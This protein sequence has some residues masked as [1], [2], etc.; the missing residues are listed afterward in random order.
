MRVSLLKTISL[1]MIVKNEEHVLERCL[2]SVQNKVHEIIIVDTGSTDST[3]QIAKKFTNKIFSFNWRDDF[4]AARN[5]SIK[6]ATSDYILILDADEYLNSEADLVSDISDSCDYY[7]VAIKNIVTR[8]Q[9]FTH[10]GLRMFKNNLNFKYENRLHEHINVIGKENEYLSG[11]MKS[12]IYHLG[13]TEQRMLEKDKNNRNKK[14][15]SLEVAEN[16]TAFNLFNMGKTFYLVSD[17]KKAVEYFERSYPLSLDR[18]YLP[19]L[20]TKL[21]QSLFEI[22][23]VDEALS[24]IKGAVVL[25]PNDTEVRFTQGV[26]F[27]ELNYFRDAMNSFFKCLELGD[28]GVVVTEGSGSY[29]SYLKITE[30]YVKKRFYKEAYLE[31]LKA[32]EEKFTFSIIRYLELTKQRRIPSGEVIGVI[33]KLYKIDEI[34]DLQFLLEVLYRVRH[35]LFNHYLEKYNVSPQLHVK[36][37]AKIYSRKYSEAFE[38]LNSMKDIN[39]EIAIDTLLFSYIFKDTRLLNNIQMYLNLGK[40][41]MKSLKQLL[42]SDSISVE[43]L[44]KN[45]EGIVLDLLKSLVVLKEYELFQALSGKLIG[46]NKRYI[47]DISKILS[48]YNFDELAIDMLQLRLKDGPK[49]IKIISMLGDLYYQNQKVDD[50]R[51]FYLKLLEFDPSY[52]SYERV[53]NLYE[54][55]NDTKNCLKIKKEIAEKF[56]VVSW[57]E[58]SIS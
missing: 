15:M 48:E 35:P 2:L 39:S 31:I 28:Q 55:L 6:H 47:L 24:V 22:G 50:A 42:M 40:S 21:A 38:I 5:E 34:K 32:L 33:D 3:I 26:L 30:I 13:Y 56:P 36:F 19:E 52:S 9:I 53:Y 18:M 12:V 49:D 1:C 45:V 54:S 23:H 4:S 43:Q 58:E 16:P 11:Q 25:F 14:L 44:T 41:E 51:L 37:I 29:L 8:E 27:F 10:T 17:Y 46:F 7:Y 20:L 57:V